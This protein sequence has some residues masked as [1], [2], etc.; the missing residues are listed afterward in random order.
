MSVQALRTGALAVAGLA[1]A[2]AIAESEWGVNLPYGV[3]PI[4]Q[5]IYDI[6]MVVFWICVAIGVGVFLAMFWSIFAYRKSK[7][8]KA[9]HFHENTTVEVIWTVVPLLILIGMAVPATQTLVK[10]YDT[11]DAELDVKITGYQWRWRYE[12]IEEEI[13]FFSNPTTPTAQRTGASE[14]GPNYLMEVD[15]HLVLPANRKV[16]F[17]ITANDVIHSWWVNDFGV[18]QD[19]I[20]G[21]VNEAW[22]IV[23]EPGIYRGLCAELCGQGHAFMPIVVEVLPEDEYDEWMAEQIRETHGDSAAEGD[24]GEVPVA[25]LNQGN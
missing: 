16:R 1:P 6:H 24:D 2:S 22:A 14:K 10:M 12:Y 7:G 4:S 18:K 23:K 21:F 11:S 15:N 17:L 3:T 20:P 5:S 19:A 8:A 9:A 13:D 25:T